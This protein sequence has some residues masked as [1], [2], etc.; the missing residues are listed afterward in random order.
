MHEEARIYRFGDVEVD[1][2]A[3][4]VM[5]AGAE[6]ALEP[7]AYAVLLALLARPG[8]AIE[9]DELLDLVWGHRHV[10][11]G[12]L[13]RVVAQ[14]RRALGDDAEH[15]RYIQTLHAVGYRFMWTPETMAV[16]T[17]AEGENFPAGR[18]SGE[19]SADAVRSGT[20]GGDRRRGQGGDRRRDHSGDRRGR[21]GLILALLALAFMFALIALVV[22]L[23]SRYPAT[24][25]PGAPGASAA[26]RPFTAIGDDPD[27]A[28]RAGGLA[29]GWKRSRSATART[30]V[31]LLR[32]CGQGPCARSAA[33]C[34]GVP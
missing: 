22:A 29:S 10:T 4:R 31:K 5:R 1:T 28:W 32:C 30:G 6:V 18:R 27:D 16:E 23:W 17:P 13:N 7:K 11:P 21:A 25:S 3:H 26:V 33:R 9:R 12:V 14:L 19:I 34:A 20:S 15:P 24:D 2:A 8:F